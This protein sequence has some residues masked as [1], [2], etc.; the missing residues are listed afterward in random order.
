M[1]RK[2]FEDMFASGVDIVATPTAPSPAFKIGEK[3]SDP[4]QMYLAD[5]FTVPANIVG[6]PA[7][8]MP[9]GFAE[10]PTGSKRPRLPVGIQFM[11][12]AGAEAILFG[13][14]KSFA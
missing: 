14:A 6:I 4:L 7:I 13:L 5:I 2:E 11:A 10:E 12:P 8:S 9:S 1:I 3:I